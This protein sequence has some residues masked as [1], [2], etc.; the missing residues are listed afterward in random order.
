MD[1]QQRLRL[2]STLIQ[3]N[4]SWLGTLLRLFMQQLKTKVH[5]DLSLHSLYVTMYII[6]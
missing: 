2:D 4:Q 6:F 5:A 3:S 1:I